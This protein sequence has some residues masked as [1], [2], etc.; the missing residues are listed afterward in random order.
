MLKGFL[1]PVVMAASLLGLMAG[2]VASASNALTQ[3]DNETVSPVRFPD[4]EPDP[5]LFLPGRVI[6]AESVTD[7]DFGRVALIKGGGVMRMSPGGVRELSGGLINLGGSWSAAEIRLVGRP[8]RYF[9]VIPQKFA[10]LYSQN[11]S[12]DLFLRNINCSVPRFGQFDGNGRAHFSC[13]GNISVK[14]HTRP[15]HYK[16]RIRVLVLYL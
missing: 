8:D 5:N 2:A 3:I 11:H 10:Q 9:A 7:L 4:E 14:G 13:G 15:A 12:S 1:I 16:G 6:Q